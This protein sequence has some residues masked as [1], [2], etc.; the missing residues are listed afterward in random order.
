MS[1][2]LSRMVCR[3]TNTMEFAGNCF[4]RFSKSANGRSL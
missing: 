3:M 4:T 1:W 2:S